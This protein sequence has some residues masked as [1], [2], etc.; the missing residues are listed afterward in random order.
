LGFVNDNG[1]PFDLSEDIIVGHDFFVGSEEDV[2]LDLLVDGMFLVVDE[3]KFV[4]LNDVKIV[5]VAKEVNYIHISPF[6]YLSFPVIKSGKRGN[7][8]KRSREFLK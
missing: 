6:S 1:L 2:K 7:Y 4:L 8:Q 3:E 5:P